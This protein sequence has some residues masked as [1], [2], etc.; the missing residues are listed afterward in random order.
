MTPSARH[1]PR[2]PSA[3]APGPAPGSPPSPAPGRGVAWR[4]AAGALPVLV[5]LSIAAPADAGS[6]GA[7]FGREGVYAG[8]FAGAGPASGR[9]VDVDGFSNWGV[10]GSTLAYG[11]TGF[12][13]G[14]LIGKRFALGGLPLR[15]ELD[16]ASGDLRA[17]SN[18]LDPEGRDETVASEFEWVATARAGVEQAL[19][20]ATLFVSAGLA[21]ARTDHSVRDLDRDLGPDGNPTPWRFDPDDSFRD[22]ST[23][24][25]W[26]VGIGVEAPLAKAWVLRLEGSYMDFG[27]S[28]HHVNH[29]GNGR[30]GPG[31]PRRPC[32][33]EIGKRLGMMRLGV[34]Y[35]FGG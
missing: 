8:L 20:A 6:E 22:R 33:Y 11:H 10:P 9:I 35:R 31:G 28:T 30:C 29:S 17:K 16:G 32:P 24:L 21:A 14:A 26:V 19:G 3:G 4:R 18:R 7:A 13:G 25:G 2:D 23:E 12:A 27:R 34:I 1:D 5:L 15:F